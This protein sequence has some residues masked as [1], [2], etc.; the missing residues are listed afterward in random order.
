MLY[1]TLLL[2]TLNA[3]LA[4]YLTPHEM[5]LIHCVQIVGKKN[6]KE[7]TKSVIDEENVGHDDEIEVL[8]R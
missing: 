6:Q 5:F 4:G 8:E 3:S 2:Q 7:H 1:A